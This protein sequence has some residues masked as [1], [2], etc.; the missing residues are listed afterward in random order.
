MHTSNELIDVLGT[1]RIVIEETQSTAYV[2]RLASSIL[3]TW[4]Q[5][6]NNLRYQIIVYLPGFVENLAHSALWYCL[7]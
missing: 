2:D 4:T 6:P 1:L 5:M 3:Y 7:F